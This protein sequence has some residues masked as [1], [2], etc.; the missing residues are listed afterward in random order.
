MFAVVIAEVFGPGLSFLFLDLGP[1]VRSVCVHWKRKIIVLF[2]MKSFVPD[3]QMNLLFPGF[4]PIKF[5]RALK[6]ELFK[7]IFQSF[8]E[9]DR[10]SAGCVKGR[11]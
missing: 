9:L 11:Q 3:V 7:K 8:F 6:I 10:I 2:F 5:R 1:G 4:S